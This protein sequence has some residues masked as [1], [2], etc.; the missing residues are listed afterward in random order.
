[1]IPAM[2][3]LS[4]VTPARVFLIA[5]AVRLAAVGVTLAAGQG[6]EFPDTA[7][8]VGMARNIAEGE[9]W[10]VQPWARAER[11]PLYPLFL[12][13]HLLLAGGIAP[14]LTT[15]A[16]L[17]AAAC[18]AAARIGARLW[19]PRAGA[20]AGLLAAAY[21]PLVFVS[22]RFLSEA[23][24]IPIV[25]AQLLAAVEAGR[26]AFARESRRAAGWAL[27]AGALGGLGTLARAAHLL[28]PLALAAAF[29]VAWW[30]A[31]QLAAP[32][33]AAILAGGVLLLVAAHL[34]VVAPWTVRNRVVLGA[35]VPV[36]TQSGK[37]LYEAAFPGATG[38]PVEWRDH[39]AARDVAGRARGLDEVA[40]DRLLRAEAWRSIRDNPLRFASLAVVKLYRLWTP[41]PNHAPYRHP[42]VLAAA[43]LVCAPVLVLAF[44]GALRLRRGSILVVLL[45]A[46]PLYVTLLHTVFIGSIRYRL[47][48]EP[49]LLLLAAWR[50]AGPDETA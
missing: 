22:T 13:L 46:L 43:V 1:M 49:V 19:G 39:P 24:Y 23:V 36:T 27:L 20:L 45:L 7:H 16:V 18:A 40:E 31:R 3:R 34:L 2:S 6:G 11:P 10:H 32:D 29:A 8:Y 50:L 33:G 9:G 44:L 35:F 42:L 37:A 14:A 28:F 30:R 47:P 25:V 4:L 5:L 12:A 15:Q 17:G 38:G 41:V 48:V 26:A 21:P